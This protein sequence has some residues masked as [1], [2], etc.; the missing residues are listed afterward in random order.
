MGLKRQDEAVALLKAATQ[1]APDYLPNWRLLGQ[2]ASAA[3]NDAEATEYLSKVLAKNPLDMEAG[4]LQSQVW[5]R[6]NE[7]AKAVELLTELTK[8]LP[9]R[10]N[11]EIALCRAYLASDEYRKAAEILDR[12]LVAFPE[13]I[14]AL[15]LRSGLFLKDGQP[16]EVIRLIEPLYRAQPGNRGVQEL[17]L[18]A[19]RAANRHDEA[20]E[21]LTK[22]SALTPGDAEVHFQLGQFLRAQGKNEQARGAFDRVLKLAP[23]NIG[24]VSQLV[25]LDQQE[26]K[27]D[28]AMARVNA[29]LAAHPDSSQGYL[30]KAGLCFTRKEFKEAEAAAEKSVALNPAESTAYGLLVRIQTADGRAAAAVERLKKLLETSPDNR[31]ARLY[32]GTL[33]QKLG[34]IDEARAALQEMVKIAPDF[35]PGYNN[36]A[37]LE[38]QVPGNLEQALEHARKA[39]SLAPNDPAISDTLGWIEWQRGS[40]RQALPLILEAANL[41]EEF[42]TVQYHLGMAHYM[43]HQI[44]DAITKL[45]KALATPGD[46]PEKEEARSY[47]SVLREAD[48]WDLATLEKR[49]NEKPKDVVLLLL[50]ANKL[51]AAGRNEDALAAYQAAL[52][53]N[54][55]LEAAYLGQAD[56]YNSSLKLPDKALEAANQA[57]RVAPQ[58]ARAA[59]MLGRLSFRS[60]DFQQAFELLQEAA[61]KLPEDSEIQYDA[62]WAAYSVGRIADARSAMGKVAEADSSRFESARQFL[63][64]TAPDAA[65]DPSVPALVEKTLAKTADHVPALMVGAS[66]QLKSGQAP[67][68]TYN[69]VL[70]IYPQFDTARIALARIYLDDPNQL[71]AAEKLATEARERQ[72]DDPELGGILGIV[73]FRKGQFDIAAQLLQELSVK[74]P[75][76]G[77]ELFALGM[78]QSA[79][80]RPKEARKNLAEA[81]KSEL[82]EADAAKAKET[83]ADLD[84]AAENDKK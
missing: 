62:G 46:F 10:H 72:K 44:P 13:S 56:L 40:F 69:K 61:R 78:S 71:E 75:L 37:Y 73:N 81:L 4:L 60:G 53:V 80:K 11:L 41:L 55:D 57:R 50:R 51:A 76:S 47:L 23:D 52:A 6:T 43:M 59:A 26:G 1:K 28:A 2:I 17:L 19:Y 58:S 25:V 14:E 8:A 68:E 79:V 45:E 27:G 67:I 36:L 35:A 54:A 7:P 18:S 12:A 22:Q 3:G 48:Q 31:E 74:R 49:L 16:L 34:R 9:M 33:L 39:R 20:V 30:L 5:L 42:A 84:K 70:A 38:S 65:E 64:L 21:L 77:R 24:A 29:Y 32:L 15:V 63:A 82:P 83:L 66:I